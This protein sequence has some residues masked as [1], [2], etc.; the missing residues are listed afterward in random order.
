MT[1]SRQLQLALC[2]VLVLPCMFAERSLA[3]KPAGATLQPVPAN[4]SAAFEASIRTA[5]PAVRAW[6][7]SQAERFRASDAKAAA[8]SLSSAIASRFAASGLAGGEAQAIA[9]LVYVEALNKAREEHRQVVERLAQLEV[10]ATSLAAL[11]QQINSAAEELASLEKASPRKDFV[12]EICDRVDA[13]IDSLRT[14]RVDGFESIRSSGQR[15]SRRVRLLETRAALKA[16]E[17]KIKREG[18]SIDEAKREASERFEFA[19]NAAAAEL[20]AA[21][22]ATSTATVS[23]TATLK[24]TSSDSTRKKP[25]FDIARLR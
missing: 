11:R 19:M 4:V 22:V 24:G 18:S 15:D 21:V 1:T 6:I 7:T 23:A 3:Q 14:A 8:R 12:C 17:A 20:N 9:F 25:V 2:A 5:Q 10:L 13:R 16:R